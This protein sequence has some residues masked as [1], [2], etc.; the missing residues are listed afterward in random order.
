[1]D[2]KTAIYHYCNYQ[3][4][5]HQEVRN[6][7]YELGAYTAQVEELISEL[8]QADLLNEE[9]YATAIAR[10]KFRLK[11]WGKN[12][13][14]QQL[15]QQKISDYCIKRAMKEIEPEEY[16]KVLRGLT[17]K[18]WEEL[19]GERSTYIRRGKV[20]RYMVQKGYETDLVQDALNEII[21]P[22]K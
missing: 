7:L 3:P 19:K 6:K 21:N 14:L 9:R 15:R 8:I 22:A 10:G 12:K 17:E 2:I 16:D 20:F 4:R 11:K 1:M 18:K 5:S 13:I